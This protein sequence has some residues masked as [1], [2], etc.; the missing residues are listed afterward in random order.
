MIEG[1]D[2]DIRGDEEKSWEGDIVTI[3]G[4]QYRVVSF[5]DKFFEAT[6]KFTEEFFASLDSERVDIETLKQEGD[7]ETD[8]PIS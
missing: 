2:S 6:R 5:S 1:K 3:G 8:K 7:G 4:I